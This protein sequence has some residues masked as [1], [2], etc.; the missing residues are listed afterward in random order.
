MRRFIESSAGR[1]FIAM[2]AVAAAVGL[3]ALLDPWVGNSG[4]TIALYGA[5]AVAVW[6]GGYRPGIVAALVGYL[7]VNYFFIEPRGSIRFE[8][9]G[10]FGRFIGYVIST[11]LIIALGGAMHSARRRAEFDAEAAHRHARDLEQEVADHRRTR[12]SLE[13]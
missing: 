10:D 9:L 3:R 5:V 12:A 7:A 8:T 2:A 13:S 1:Y 11:G 4:A 6:A